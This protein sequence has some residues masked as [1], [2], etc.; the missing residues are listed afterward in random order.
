M[1]EKNKV[2]LIAKSNQSTG[3]FK[4]YLELEEIDRENCYLDSLGDIGRITEFAGRICY[5]SGYK[6]QKNRNSLEYHRNIINLNHFSIYGHIN[7]CVGIEIGSLLK[8]PEVIVELFKFLSKS[9]RIYLRYIENILYLN[10]SLRHIIE[11]IYFNKLDSFSKAIVRII[12]NSN[13]E[14]LN[15]I[16]QVFEIDILEVLG[17]ESLGILFYCPDDVFKW[18]SFYIYTSRRTANELIRHNTEYAVSQQS[19]RYVLKDK[20]KIVDVRDDYLDSN[21]NDIRTDYFGMDLRRKYKF[22]IEYL[23]ERIYDYLKIF[24]KNSSKKDLTGFYANFIPNGIDTELVFSCTEWQF[25]QI[26]IQRLTEYSDKNIFDLVH[27]MNSVLSISFQG[28]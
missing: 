4:N 9:K 2:F 23:L 14:L 15:F 13:I 8:E 18:Y 1:F 10:I 25:E 26:K 27:K 11:L 22:E 16:E 17:D 24:R 19:T 3:F 5:R 21:I 28:K 12:I 20:V 6:G 7:Y